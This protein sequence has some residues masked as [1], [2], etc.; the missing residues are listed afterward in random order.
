MDL[1]YASEIIMN[2]D[3]DISNFFESI[4]EEE[5]ERFDSCDTDDN[6]IIDVPTHVDMNYSQTQKNK[7]I[8]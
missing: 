8:C 7:Y 5:L 3:S 2:D 4:D 6:S 1:N